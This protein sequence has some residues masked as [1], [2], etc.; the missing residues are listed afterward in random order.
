MRKVCHRVASLIFGV[1][2]MG[3]AGSYST[4]AAQGSG[5]HPVGKG[6]R[7][8]HSPDPGH[9]GLSGTTGNGIAY[10]GGPIMGISAGAPIKVYYIWYGDWATQDSGANTIL[11]TLA[12]GIGGSP[13]FNINTTYFNS[14]N[15]NLINAVS[16][17][18]AVNDNYSQG[19]A[20]GDF[21]SSGTVE[22][23]VAAHA[24]HDLPLDSNG[25]YF[26]LTTPDV[27]ETS[28]FCTVYCGWHTYT[29]ING[30]NV[31]F[32]FIGDP[33]KCPGACEIQSV[34]PN[35]SGG[36]DGM[37]SVVS[38]E[39]EE[40][41]TD[42]DI[43][44]WYNNV[45]G[46]AQ[47]NAD[48]CAWTFGATSHA[49]NGALYNMTLGGLNY[50]IQQNWV[51]AAGGY[52]GLTYAS[53]P[54]FSLSP[55][56]SSQTVLPAGGAS[57]TINVGA[58]SGFTGG[59]TLSVTGGLPSGAAASFTGSPVAAPGSAT[60][61]VTT[62]STTPPGSYTLTIQGVSG[63]LTHTASVT[64][65]VADFTISASPSSRS[66]ATGTNTTYTVTAGALNGFTSNV[67]LSLSGLPTGATFSF[68]PSSVSGSGSSTLTVMTGTGAVGGPYALTIT[69]TSSGLGPTARAALPISAF[70]ISASPA[71]VTVTQGSSTTSTVT[72]AAVNGFSGTVGF[73]VTGLPSGLTAS[74]VPTSVTGPGSSTLKLTA[75]SST[76]SGSYPL[77]VV[78]AS[79]A[80]MRSTPISVTVNAGAGSI[81]LSASPSNLS[82]RRSSTNSGTI[83][84]TVTPVGGFSGSV[85]LGTSGLPAGATASFSP[86]SVTL[87][88]S[89]V[90]SSLTI[91]IG[92]G[93]PNGNSSFNVIASG[94]GA[95]QAQ[96]T[97]TL[98]VRN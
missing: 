46:S 69:R 87:S 91:T 2:L 3:C 59:V 72:V 33:L 18:G 22:S 77:T 50:L 62:S 96:V 7:T 67:S 24:G 56:P 73:S 55:S 66:A 93:T 19:K 40:A 49:A 76:T 78:G 26:V 54:D 80:L 64:L 20:L 75:A 60:M 41:A 65:N 79:G 88:G 68:S 36:G 39:L 44:A 25:V 9:S 12:Q 6:N 32:A 4:V 31:K 98:H 74:F 52:C 43:S 5:D 42:P 21:G 47:E 94:A 35:G 15:Q 1:L 8:L 92:S 28:G 89:A 27:S 57:Y 38:H 34:G 45:G 23:V 17:G 53:S 86:P 97:V 51:N 85:A 81:S 37:A 61:N 30:V 90:T 84:V 70:T 10:N 63:T 14:S 29:V 16:F 71:S 11:T 82:L 83:T 58:L 48:M 13:Y 95:P